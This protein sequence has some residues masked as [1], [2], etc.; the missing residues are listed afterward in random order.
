[1]K[2]HDAVGDPILIIF[3]GRS[4][5]AFDACAYVSWELNIVDYLKVA[6]FCPRTALLPSR[7][8]LM[9]NELCVAII[10]N[11]RLKVFIQQQ[12]RSHLQKL[13][14]IV[15]SQIVN[16]MIQKDCYGFNTF[17]TT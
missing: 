13:N 4:S 2:P 14:H 10:I 6:W 12:C 3:S 8:C 11:K 5:Q 1:M 15:D 16:A 9:I 17:A 7:R